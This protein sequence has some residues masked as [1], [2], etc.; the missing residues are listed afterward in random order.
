MEAKTSNHIGHIL[1]GFKEGEDG[2]IKSI[3]HGHCNNAIGFEFLMNAPIIWIFTRAVWLMMFT[4]PMIC[5]F[6]LLNWRD[7]R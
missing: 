7:R 6:S 3:V 2:Y 1:T 4:I 5:M